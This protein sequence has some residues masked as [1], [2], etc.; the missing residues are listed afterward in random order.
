MVKIQSRPDIPLAPTLSAP[1]IEE[2]FT[3]ALV[4][5]PVEHVGSIASAI[6]IALDT[7]GM[8]GEYGYNHSSSHL[9]VDM[10]VIALDKWVS[11]SIG[12]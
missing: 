11:L 5:E 6:L 8:I 10:F 3:R 12:F 2:I 1:Q 9:N 4:F 7:L